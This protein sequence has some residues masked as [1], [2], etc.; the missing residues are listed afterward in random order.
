M[1]V[2]SYNFSFSNSTSGI[3]LDSVNT[4]PCAD[5]VCEYLP[6]VS[7]YCRPMGNISVAVSA[8]N[9]LGIGL[10]SDPISVG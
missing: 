4:S 7:T 6:D 3:M 9:E 2:I 1:P 5:D 10:P 8:A